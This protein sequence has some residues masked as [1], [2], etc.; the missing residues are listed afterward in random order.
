MS[1]D[2]KNDK[3]PKKKENGFQDKLSNGFKSTLIY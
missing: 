3:N 1:P 2:T